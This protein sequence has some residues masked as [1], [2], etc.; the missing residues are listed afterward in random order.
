M[1]CN[2]CGTQLT[3]GTKFCTECGRAT[4]A[5]PQAPVSTSQPPV[6]TPQPPEK[7]KKSKGGL[8]ALIAVVL[9][10]AIL[11]GIALIGHISNQSAYDKAMELYDRGDYE[12][13]LELF[14]ELGDFSSSER[15]AERCRKRLSG[16][17]APTVPTYT[18]DTEPTEVADNTEPTEPPKTLDLTVQTAELVYELT[19]E[20]VELFY[21]LL[22]EGEELAMSSEDSEE[23]SL[24]F[25]AV[26]DAYEYLL[27][28]HGIAMVQYYCD[29][30]D[31]EASELYLEVTDIATEANDAYMQA[32]R[33]IY[34]SDSIHNEV[35]FQDWTEE[36]LRMLELY[37]DEVMRLEQ[38]NSEI[39]VAYQGM[40]DSDTMYDDM[41]PLY[42]EMVQNNNRI[43]Q[44]YGYD[45]YYTYAYE[46]VYNRDY[47][48]DS[49][50]AMR[51]YCSQYLPSATEGALNEAIAGIQGISYSN[52]TLLSNILWEDYSTV[53]KMLT[54]YLLTL[55][56]SVQEAF[57]DMFNGNILLMQNTPNA[58]EGAFTTDLTEDHLV[59]FFGPGYSN[60]L[61]VLHEGGH[62]YGGKHQVLSDLPMDLA[63]TQSQGNE[64]LFTAYLQQ[65]R[66]DELSEAIAD[67]KMYSDLT[68]ILICVIVDEFEEAVYTHP[69]I[70]SLTGDD[71]D[72]M[73]EEVCERYGGVEFLGEV[74]TDI[75]NYWRMVVVEQ[76]V[77]YISYGV[78][79][80]AA[81][82]VYTIAVEDYAAGIEAY[83]SVVE[84]VD[85]DDGFLGNITRAGLDGPFDEEV[86][87][88]LYDMFG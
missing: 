45:N 47:G 24:H 50:E 34:I 10:A 80:I 7:P 38:R 68:T 72:A 15:Y 81:M 60:V 13:A 53:K 21:R 14:M 54:N 36:E 48:S 82:N 41:V 25:D 12:E 87:Q 71:L 79:A 32:A 78:S 63:E 40:Q 62:Y 76:P 16:S 28:Q 20:D 86:Y 56:D 29:L 51:Q 65:A 18:P 22:E 27:T 31:E 52:R 33:R 61:T 26:D 6:S 2:H 44:I 67:Y 43:A 83:C 46:Q 39:E 73:M 37:T 75:Q 84:D 42:I 17:D 23:V 58:M 64:W 74:A 30:E 3:D 9:V 69:N 66:G 49:I 57:Q 55:P 8:I 59:C 11:G 85:L 4:E 88:T 1:F 35:L 5:P 77:Y 19:D 70:A